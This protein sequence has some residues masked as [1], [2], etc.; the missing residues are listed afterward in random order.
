MHQVTQFRCFALKWHFS[1]INLGSI[2]GVEEIPGMG[3]V[4]ILIG[5]LLNVDK[6]PVF[7]RKRERG[8]ESNSV[9]PA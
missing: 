2:N 7:D 3:N 5:P 9:N 8:N 1:N 4:N 6:N